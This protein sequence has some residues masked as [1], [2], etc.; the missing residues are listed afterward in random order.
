MRLDELVAAA[1]SNGKTGQVAGYNTSTELFAVYLFTDTGGVVGV[2]AA[3]PQVVLAVKAANLVKDLLPK[4]GAAEKFKRAWTPK[5]PRGAGLGHNRP[6][7]SGT[8][9]Q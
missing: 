5:I 9:V 6:S 3:K 8:R 1:H 2:L 4:P 7:V